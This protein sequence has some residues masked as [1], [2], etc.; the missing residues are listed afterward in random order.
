MTQTWQN[1]QEILKF[2]ICS[3]D[4]GS[5]DEDDVEDEDGEVGTIFS[6]V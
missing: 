4:E 5:A 3:D 6:C 2:L 1:V